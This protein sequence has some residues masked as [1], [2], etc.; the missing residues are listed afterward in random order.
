MVA[1]VVV[2]LA[3]CAFD[4]HSS[5]CPFSLAVRLLSGS[6]PSPPAARNP[7]QG[8]RSRPL[9]AQTKGGPQTVASASLIRAPITPSP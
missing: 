9:H 5:G 1:T 4:G 2:T 6:A 7:D 3:L 8:P